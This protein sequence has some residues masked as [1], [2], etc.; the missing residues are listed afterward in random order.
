VNDVSAEIRSLLDRQ[1]IWD[2]LMRYTGEVDRL[3]AEL[4]RSAYWPDAFD[5]HGALSGTPEQFI[6]KLFSTQ[7]TRE[8][9]QHFVGNH[10]V[11]LH[12]DRADVET[13]FLSSAKTADSSVLRLVADRYLDR[14]ERRDDEWRIKDRVVVLDWQ[15]DAD[16][17]EMAEVLSGRI[18]G[19]RN[20]D[21][22]SYS[23]K[24]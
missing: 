8:A 6:A 22:P 16:A 23:M 17:S 20:R 12:G 15:C 14:F 11:Q 18:H 13:Y 7:T 24:E 4:I 3:D 1:T 10:A 2:C 21:D 9:G 19:L 5:S